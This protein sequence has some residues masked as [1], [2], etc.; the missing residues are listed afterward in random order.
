MEHSIVDEQT[1]SELRHARDHM[2]ETNPNP[3]S[4]G[5]AAP[6][7][8]WIGGE[9][10]KGTPGIYF[11]GIATRGATSESIG[12]DECRAWSEE[13]T[14]HPPSTPFWRYIRETTEAV[15]GR[16]YPQCTSRIAWSNQFKIGIHNLSG[17]E[18]L[19]P[20][21]FYAEMQE[22]LCLSIL[23]REIQFASTSAVIFLGDGPLIYPLVGQGDWDKESYRNLG[24]W[25]KR[26]QNSAL[27]LYQYHPKRLWM[28]GPEHFSQHAQTVASTVRSFFSKILNTLHQ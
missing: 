20:S 21:G 9:I 4:V 19:N 18:S 7:V 27:I 23:Q 1:F 25:M 8:P 24:V 3:E 12:F 17:P 15:Y 11:I 6:F 28:Q 2:I 13:I 16:R 14:R 26:D 5:I 22:K 10:S